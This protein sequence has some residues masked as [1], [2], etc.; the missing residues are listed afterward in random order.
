M[1]ASS[2]GATAWMIPKVRY[3]RGYVSSG[4]LR[5]TRM[6]DLVGELLGRLD[7]PPEEPALERGPLREALGLD[8]PPAS[9]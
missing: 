7:R 1:R 5:A 4:R 3:Q 9:R 8:E 2:D 6:D